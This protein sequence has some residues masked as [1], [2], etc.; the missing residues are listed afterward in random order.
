MIRIRKAGLRSLQASVILFIAIVITPIV[1]LFLLRLFVVPEVIC[2]EYNDVIKEIKSGKYENIPN[3]ENI[4]EAEKLVKGIFC[5]FFQSMEWK[6]YIPDKWEKGSITYRYYEG[7]WKKGTSPPEDFLMRYYNFLTNNNQIGE[8]LDA[9]SKHEDLFLPN[10]NNIPADCV[11]REK[12]WKTDFKYYSG[13]LLDKIQQIVNEQGE[14]PITY[15]P[16]DSNGK[17]NHILGNKIKL[18]LIVYLNIMMNLEEG[19][20]ALALEWIKEYGQFL[21]LLDEGSSLFLNSV[22]YVLNLISFFPF[23]KTF[24]DYFYEELIDLLI[25]IKNK[26]EST[27]FWKEFWFELFMIEEQYAETVKNKIS[28]IGRYRLDYELKVLYYNRQ[29]YKSLASIVE[30]YRPILESATWE[31]A[32]EAVFYK[33]GELVSFFDSVKQHAIKYDKLIP[34]NEYDSNPG[35][36]SLGGIKYHVFYHHLWLS[37]SYASIVRVMLEYYRSCYGDFPESLEDCFEDYLTEKEINWINDSLNILFYENSYVIHCFA[38]PKHLIA[39]LPEKPGK[40]YSA[41]IFPF[42]LY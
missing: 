10:K 15:F 34:I 20:Y 27:S 4:R 16:Y 11:K 37:Y 42:A 24:P 29:A 40:L 3:L 6:T 32:E 18:D 41:H 22:P 13:K 36:P 23:Y 17:M 21:I 28:S 1:S 35:T 2:T 25:K 26:Y 8:E 19:D 14:Q 31:D 39:K 30:K 33:R 5:S 7:M 9:Y 12:D 38:M